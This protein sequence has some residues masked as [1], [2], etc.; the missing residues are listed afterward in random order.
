[1]KSGRISQLYL[2]IRHCSVKSRDVTS[3]AHPSN[4]D[5]S[6]EVVLCSAG[7]YKMITTYC[8]GWANAD[9]F[10]AHHGAL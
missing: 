7:L 4:P 1:M 10:M 3:P 5:K 6:P 2:D 8:C 9:K